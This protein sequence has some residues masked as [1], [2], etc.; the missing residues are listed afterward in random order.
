MSNV[1]LLTFRE[2]YRS[3]LCAGRNVASGPG[4][5]R[6]PEA[7]AFKPEDTRAMKPS[8]GEVD[9][10]HASDGGKAGKP[11][12]SP[13]T[14]IFAGFARLPAGAG[15]LHG[16][17]VLALELEVDPYD[18]RIVDAACDCIPALGQK[19]LTGL[20][21]GSILNDGLADTVAAIRSR[22]FSITQ[23]A[24][25]AA[26]QDLLKRY[27]EFREKEGDPGRHL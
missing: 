1:R 12:V 7:S 13:P 22:Y 27:E 24:M 2:A 17:G 26:V 8:T 11:P 14:F 19:F 9:G 10:S 6:R 16:E 25:I 5:D 18:M 4:R 3:I 23:R 15:V 20:L 21:V